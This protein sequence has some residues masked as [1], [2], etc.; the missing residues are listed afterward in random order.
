MR[1]GNREQAKRCV[2]LAWDGDL[3]GGPITPESSV[4]ELDDLNLR[5]QGMLY[6]D[7][8]TTVGQLAEATPLR[9]QQVN[10]LGQGTIREVRRVL[11][12]VREEWESD[13][14]PR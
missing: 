1:L 10:G 2:D 7:G 4:Y 13:L 6:A 5:I 12:R 11:E 9:I 3:D 14:P 8:I